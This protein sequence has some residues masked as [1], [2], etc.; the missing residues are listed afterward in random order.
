MC[1]PVASLTR[2]AGYLCIQRDDKSSLPR[3]VSPWVPRPAPKLQLFPGVLVAAK[4]LPDVLESRETFNQVSMTLTDS[5]SRNEETSAA[6]A[7][8]NGSVDQAGIGVCLKTPGD[9][10]VQ[11]GLRTPAHMPARVSCLCQSWCT[12]LKPLFSHL[13]SQAT[14]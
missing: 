10:S 11:A 13:L 7:I 1:V 12:G 5:P 2:D 4:H 9:S 8:W 6:R 14:L 3:S